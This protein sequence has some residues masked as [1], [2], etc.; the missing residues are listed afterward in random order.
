M[1]KFKKLAVA[2][3]SVVM[4]GTMAL[5]FTACGEKD[6]GPGKQE[7]PG[8]SIGKDL[9]GIMKPDGTINYDAYKRDSAVTLNL[10]VGHNSLT[11][12][13]SY[14]DLGSEITL[15]DGVTY[16]QGD[17]KPAW[18]QMGKDLNISWGD[19]YGG[20]Q[21][22]ANLNW[23]LNTNQSGAGAD[24][25]AKEYARVD[26]F[27]TDLSYAVSYS[28][29]GT[30]DIL[31][32][33]E[34]LDYMPNFRQF[35][36]DNPVVYLSLLQ[37]G[38][39]TTNGTGQKILVAPYFDGYDDIERYCIIRHDWAK[40]LLNGDTATTS[41]AKF[42]EACASAP[43]AKSFMGS[44]NYT[45]DALTADGSGTQ[46]ITKDYGAA[47]T[48]AADES[49]PLGAAYKAIA[50][51][52]YSGDSGNIVDIM[53]AALTANANAT[54]AQLV[55]LYRAYIDVCYTK[56]GAAYFNKDN[57]ANVFVGYDACWDVDDLVAILRCVKTNAS[58]LVGS[59]KTIG[60]IAPRSGQND[61]TPD[62]VS[63]AGQLYGV[64]G[65]TSRNEF[66]YIA[67]DGTIKDARTD[68]NFYKAMENMNLL[69]R[70]NLIADYSAMSNFT[71]SSGI[72]TKTSGMDN[73]FF[74]V[75]D[76]SQTQTL[77]GFLAEDSTVTHKDFP[78]G[79]PDGYDFEPVL[80]PVSKW[81]VDADGKIA[82][83]EYF[84][85]TESWRSTKTS[86]L[87]VNGALKNDE[88][89]RK[90][91]LQFIDYLYSE[92]GQIVSTYGPMAE[93]AEGKGGFW[94]N[95][96][97]T[98]DEV[99]EGNYF[100][101][102]G[103]RYGGSNYKGNTTP[104]ITNNVYNSFKGK[105]VNGW[106][107]GD[108]SKVSGAALSFTNYARMLIGSTLP[109]G[110]KDQ[111]FENQ[112]TSEMGQRGAGR[113]GV[114]LAKGV[115][116][117]M[118]LNMDASNYWYTAVPTGLPVSSTDQTSLDSPAQQPFRYMTGTQMPEG[119]KNFFSVMNYIIL[120]GA[121]GTYNQQGVS[122]TYTSIENLLASKLGGD[123]T[124]LQLAAARQ[125]AFDG[126]WT[127]AK[128]YWTYL[129]TVAS[130]K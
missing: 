108:N 128:K 120:N 42:S 122:V 72:A 71:T 56:D 119:D 17:F 18:V 28:T 75:Y 49:K 107:T 12:S 65:A 124:V 53:N 22:N 47:K 125:F 97:A 37:D 114:A 30:A 3:V 68:A 129:S 126:G 24:T 26:L 62:M 4:A 25:A 99:R 74:M 16:S 14:K 82:A 48:A 69:R 109:V 38:M 76:Y 6:D 8:E 32:L 102:K 130:N 39:N 121:S 100:R 101:Y 112:L 27:T 89:K 67:K 9:Y 40:K 86:G 90:A 43:S 78:K 46:K 80:T 95:T 127:T 103:V 64:R 94:Y 5:S 96:A 116:K 36:N 52:A 105:P 87:A 59:G 88:A 31:N 91:A 81:D 63:L 34:Y 44:A 98:E 93:N 111:S 19:I 15:P 33:A 106:K 58:V 73:E 92:D 23:L 54:G 29:A 83:D 84:R 113:V 45:V 60:G 50:G 66:T 61:R 7:K 104:T 1:N 11:T 35:L 41:T 118:T 85:F 115:V 57:R 2:A 55:D 70:E 10:A 117:G 77:A 79:T 13:T 51:A 21:T 123:S 110:V 20:K